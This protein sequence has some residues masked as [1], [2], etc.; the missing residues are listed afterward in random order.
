MSKHKRTFN[1]GDKE[2]RYRTACERLGSDNPHC[3]L[4]H[5]ASPHA[6][7]LHHVAEQEFDDETVILCSNHHDPVSDAQKDH[8]RKIPDCTN[9]LEPIG[10]MSLGLGEMVAVI[11]EDQPDHPL[12][13]FL[14]YLRWRL[15]EIGT[16]LIEMARARPNETF[17]GVS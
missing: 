13:E 2:T 11:L 9:P 7:Q 1:H 10:H 8:P 4:G 3:L 17:G 15:Q 12:R 6:L 5:K 14:T 16:R